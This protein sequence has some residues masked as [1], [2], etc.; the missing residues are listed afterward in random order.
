MFS[1]DTLKY[2]SPW[3]GGATGFFIDLEELDKQ[4]IALQS[5]YHPDKFVRKSAA[6]MAEATATSS[7]INEEYNALKDP[8]KRARMLLPEELID[9]KPDPDLLLE[10]MELRERIELGDD[11][12]AEV[13]AQIKD[14][15]IAF[16]AALQE[17]DFAKM[18]NLFVRMQYLYKTKAEIKMMQL[19]F[20][21][22]P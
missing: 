21:M 14:V 19:S 12:S 3:G 15:E 13:N 5:Q 16:D 2:L 8:L 4:Y 22:I 11:L 9:T 7:L 20:A 6:A 17:V 1:G 10:M 18:G